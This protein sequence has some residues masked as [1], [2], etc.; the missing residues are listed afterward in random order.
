MTNKTLLTIFDD[1]TTEEQAELIEDLVRLFERCLNLVLEKNERYGN[2]WQAQGWYGNL[3]RILSKAA[4]LK[5]MLWREHEK[6][7]MNETVEDTALDLINLTSFFLLNRATDN[8][9]GR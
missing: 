6:P 3:S 5:A 8:K 4:R 1:G 2:A 7:G 9:F